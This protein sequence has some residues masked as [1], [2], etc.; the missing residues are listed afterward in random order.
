MLLAALAV[1]ARESDAQRVSMR[2]GFRLTYIG[3]RVNADAKV[4]D[5]SGRPVAS[6][7]LAYRITDPTIASV[8]P[9]GEVVAKKPGDA[10]L[11]AISGND[12]AY[13]YIQVQQQA[14]RFAFTPGF[15]RLDAIGGRQAIKILKSDAAGVPIA[16]EAAKNSSC[17]AV[18]E[19]VATLTPAGDVVAVGNGSTYIRCADRGLAD[20]IKV[21][22]RQRAASVL[23]TN[24]PSLRTKQYADTFTVRYAVK[25]PQGREI[26]DARPTFASLNPQAVSVDPVSGRAR[27]IYNG[28]AKVIAQVGD[29]ADTTSISVSGSPAIAAPPAATTTTDTATGTTNKATI[30]AQDAF[31]IEKDTGSVIVSASDSAGNAIP[32][33]QIK[34]RIA[35]T[36]VAKIVDAKDVLRVY[37]V[38][39]GSTKITVEFAG[40]TDEKTIYVSSR[41]NASAASRGSDSA[42]AG[43]AAKFVPP[44]DY[45]DSVPILKTFQDSAWK[46]I[47]TDPNTAAK[48]RKLVLS[49]GFSGAIVEHLSRPDSTVAEDRTGPLIGG[50]ATIGLFRWLELGG[51]VRKGTLQSAGN[52][53]EELSYLDGEGSIG[54]FPIE[55]LG[56]RGSYN[57][58]T[59][60]TPSAT[61][62][63]KFPRVSVITR[64]SFIGDLVNTMTAVS[65]M[66][67]ATYSDATATPSLLSL[68]G[69][70]GLEL[71][72]SAVQLGLTYFVEQFKFDNSPRVEAFSAIRF[73]LSLVG[74]R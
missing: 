55:Q 12:S 9:N 56:L 37:P 39:P 70:A 25:D 49:A 65:F 2:V 8:S 30:G 68:G 47:R 34:I 10:R 28:D 54:I 7:P 35:D 16:G 64:F 59:E 48:Q 51:T 18:N 52:V 3:M 58:R 46:T 53:G 27:A 26:L 50:S 11:W 43:A 4:L 69:E 72:V 71:R 36:S 60:K 42:R 73:K 20:S 41:N 38:K 57:L 14:S 6:A 17:R 21:D 19:R 32:L 66:P 23:I 31:L 29:I 13:A 44:P 15:V 45:K 67:K 33:T 61:Q 62:S 22:V 24:K 1:G 40:H 74:G 5:N 63:W